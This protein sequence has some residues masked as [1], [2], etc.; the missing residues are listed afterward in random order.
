MGC[1]HSE[2]H[3]HV[4]SFILVYSHHLHKQTDLVSS[5]LCHYLVCFSSPTHRTPSSNI[6]VPW[7][8]SVK[9]NSLF[10]ILVEVIFYLQISSHLMLNSSN[11]QN[12]HILALFL[13]TYY[14]IK[15]VLFQLYKPCFLSTCQYDG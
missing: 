14:K 8:R 1:S 3:S 9:K 11:N 2:A 7:W 5:S 10:L 6:G 12:E 15:G 13:Y 4:H